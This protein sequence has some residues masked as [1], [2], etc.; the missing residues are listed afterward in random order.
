M[1]GVTLQLGLR[2]HA[3]ERGGLVADLDIDDVGQ[4][5]IGALA[6]IVRAAEDV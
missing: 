6:G 2:G 1:S 3:L 4:L 5:D